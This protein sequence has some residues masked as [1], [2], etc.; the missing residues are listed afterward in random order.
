MS[1]T[2]SNDPTTA[3]PP[4]IPVK[5]KDRIVSRPNPQQQLAHELPRYVTDAEKER[6]AAAVEADMAD[7]GFQSRHVWEARQFLNAYVDSVQSWHKSYENL[8][9]DESENGGFSARAYEFIENCRR[10]G[11][12][13]KAP[14]YLDAKSLEKVYLKALS[15]SHATTKKL[16]GGMFAL[17]VAVVLKTYL[18]LG[19]AKVLLDPLM[20]DDNITKATLAIILAASLSYGITFMVRFIMMMI[21]ALAPGDAFKEVRTSGQMLGRPF[22]IGLLAIMSVALLGTL[23]TFL[24]IDAAQLA[25]SESLANPLFAA[26]GMAMLFF[27][28]VLAY[29]FFVAYKVLRHQQEPE[30]GDKDKLRSSYLA[31]L[32]RYHDEVA[33]AQGRTLALYA[34]DSWQ[35]FMAQLDAIDPKSSK[36]PVK[37]ARALETIRGIRT[38]FKDTNRRTANNKPYLK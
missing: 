11:G 21:V 28:T 19:L 4:P 24:Q 18:L 27:G 33:L 20:S 32:N 37:R 29:E 30:S 31:A 15:H 35:T 16:T 3:S 1:A 26:G 9:A 10:I 17:I 6:I 8:Q 13:V 23:I 2:F 25:G 14:K 5:A 7:L 12:R 36:A 38:D 22:T 34:Q